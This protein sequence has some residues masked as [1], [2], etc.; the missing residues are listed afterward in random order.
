MNSILRTLALPTMSITI[1]LLVLAVPA[2]DLGAQPSDGENIDKGLSFEERVALHNE[3]AAK[4]TFNEK[5]SAASFFERGGD[6]RALRR[7]ERLSLTSVPP[8]SLPEAL[9]RSDMVVEGSVLD[10]DF[11]QEDFA[12]NRVIFRVDRVLA[13]NATANS[14]LELQYPGD[15]EIDPNDGSLVLTSAAFS[16]V[17]FEGDRLL[18]MLVR[19]PGA[20]RYYT[21][22]WAGQTYVD[23]SGRL[24]ALD[25]NAFASEV[26]G[27]TIAEF[28]A[29]VERAT[30]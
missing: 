29:R 24:K 11:L 26:D 10:V 7:V 28:A 14:V 21:L 18:L 23:T 17:V 25:G 6:P 13:G 2:F 30:Q 5:E 3:L 19:V 1:A 4:S 20:D 9:D 22:E 27:L 8:A 12:G 16:P 15:I